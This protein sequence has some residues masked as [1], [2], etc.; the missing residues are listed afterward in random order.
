[1]VR[2]PGKTTSVTAGI[3]ASTTQTQGNGA[4]SSDINEVS[5]VANDADV[6][7]LPEAVAGRTV[8]VINN[9]ANTLQI[10]PA[11][12]D[13]LGAG[14][15]T[16]EELEINQSVIFVAYDATNW[17]VGA[18]TGTFHAEMVDT[19]NTDAYVINASADDHA[20]HTN[21]LAAGDLQ[22]WTFDA[23][24]AG[25]SI[26]IDSIADG[27]ANGVDIAVTTGA[28]HGLAVGD[29]VS[30]TNLTSA[31]YTGYF[32]VK[33]KISDTV[34]EVAA[35]FT[36]TDT[37]TMDQAATLKCGGAAAGGYLVLWSASATAA[38]NNHT[39]QFAIHVE[40]AHQASTNTERKFGIG[41]DIGNMG[42]ISIIDI[43]A[44]DHVSFMI[45]NVGDSGNITLKDF[46]VVLVR[47]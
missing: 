10:F 16:S 38:A 46:T 30:Q 37:G 7:T 22:G 35:V 29:I 23:G 25:T 13:D 11:S 24:G 4:L 2:I 39:F 17:H 9:G 33:A 26:A 19:L 32:V 27:A 18:A 45:L 5:T 21:G 40:A 47:L 31:V 43:A 8:T 34:Y 12:G 42:G 6:V 1:M 15:N 36:A 20:Y 44:N 14:L 3:T 41:A 28:A